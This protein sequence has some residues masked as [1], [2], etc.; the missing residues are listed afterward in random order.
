MVVEP[1][2]LCRVSGRLVPR[3]DGATW[4]AEFAQFPALEQVTKDGSTGLANGLAQVHAARRQLDH[5]AAAQDD[6]FHVLHDGRRALRQNESI[7][8]P[9]GSAPSAVSGQQAARRPEWAFPKREGL[10]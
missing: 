6:H 7:P 5:A 3:R 4:A 1:Q 2:N 10:G 9:A 8:C